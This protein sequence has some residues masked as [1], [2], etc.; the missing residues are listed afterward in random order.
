MAT[1]TA[2]S[3]L[4]IKIRLLNISPMIW[5]RILVPE[6]YTLHQLHG[7]I[8]VAM[9]WEGIHLFEFR[10]RAVEYT[11]FY[12]QG[13][14][15]D[16]PLEQFHFR[17][18]TKFTYAYDMGDYWQHEVRVE[19]RMAI[20]QRKRYPACTGGSGTCPPEDCGGSEAY[21]YKHDE[22]TGFDAIQDL[23]MLVDFVKQVALDA[24]EALRHDEE[25]RWE[26]EGAMERSQARKPYVNESF[27][28]KEVNQAFRQQRHE[29]LMHQQY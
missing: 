16:I 24:N 26:I 1:P 25:K 7:V 29:V 15:P 6:N 23:I 3:I 21:L 17:K 13:E 28:R 14:S 2:D 12:L 18:N 27:S 11:A 19:K 5:R 9:G 20:E 10:I 8:Q 4:Q 22:A